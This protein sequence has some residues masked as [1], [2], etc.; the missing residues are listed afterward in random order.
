MKTV[1][2]FADGLTYPG[3]EGVSQ[4][5]IGLLVALRQAS[6][7][8][9]VLLMCDRGT[10]NK[11]QIEDLGLACI[12]VPHS[13]YYNY[14]KIKKLINEVKPDILQSY[15]TY[16]ARLIASRYSLEYRIPLVAEHHDIDEEYVK[17]YK[18]KS[19]ATNYQLDIVELASLNR[20][21]SSRDE[22]ILKNLAPS[23]AHTLLSTPSTILSPI[24]K[25]ARNTLREPNK[26]V[27]VGNGAYPPNA[28]ALEFI[29]SELAPKLPDITFHLIGR[30]TESFDGAAPNVKTYG[31]VDD[32]SDI[33]STASFGIAPLEKGSGL[34]IKVLTYL[35]AGLPVIG[36]DIAFQ[37]YKTSPV[38][39]KAGLDSFANAVQEQVRNYSLELHTL[40]TDEY[41]QNYHESTNLER[42][43]AAYRNLTYD[44][45]STEENS[46]VLHFDIKNLPWL[47]EF[48]ENPYPICT[49]TT[50]ININH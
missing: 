36:T 43:I 29:C 40:A 39:I 15:S 44:A 49:D 7:I 17:S 42:L 48:R 23:R 14:N 24:K 3:K 25:V 37:G 35:A 19:K 16:Q 33:L 18:L 2:L 45:K 4:H 12:L 1:L 11:S 31:M 46:R 9:P 32:I 38:L 10:I 50:Y 21:L 6:K 20:T 28:K 41:Q 22:E 27:F 5:V 8:R 13:I 47:K 30:L 26:I 34:K